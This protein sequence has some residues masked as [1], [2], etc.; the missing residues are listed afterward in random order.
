MRYENCKA[1]DVVFRPSDGMIVE[2]SFDASGNPIGSTELSFGAA[3]A[4]FKKLRTAIQVAA[5]IGKVSFPR[6]GQTRSDNRF[7]DDVFVKAYDPNVSPPFWVECP[8]GNELGEGGW[9]DEDQIMSR[10]PEVVPDESAC[11]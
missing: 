2:T 7:V 4:L 5:M 1:S 10:W 11:G 6:T 3:Y 9:Y 8:K